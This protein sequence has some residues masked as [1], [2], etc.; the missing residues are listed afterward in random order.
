[1][2]NYIVYNLY[3]AGLSTLHAATNMPSYTRPD[4]EYF[5]AKL[6]NTFL[7]LSPASRCTGC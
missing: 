6:S 5:D 7:P 1:M 4:G 2:I 3:I